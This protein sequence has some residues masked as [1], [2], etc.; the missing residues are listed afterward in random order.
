[1]FELDIMTKQAITMA[2][3]V[4]KRLKIIALHLRMVHSQK[5]KSELKGTSWD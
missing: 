2:K 3:T 4:V 5:G 1:M